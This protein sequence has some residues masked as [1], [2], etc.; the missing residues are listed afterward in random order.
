[1]GFQAVVTS[2]QCG[3]DAQPSPRTAASHM[4][5]P[6]PC[7]DQPVRSPPGSDLQMKLNVLMKT[8]AQ[9]GLLAITILCLVAAAFA[10]TQPRQ[11]DLNFTPAKTT[12]TF[13]LSASLHTVH[14]SFDL[15]RGAVHFD[16]ATNKLSG[17]IVADATSG[18][19]ENDGRD[20]KMHE[21]VLE[22]ARYPEIVFRPDRVE[23]QVAPTGVSTIQVHG[24]FS[25]HGAEHEMTIP[26]RV[27]IAPAHWIAT[28][29]FAIPYVKWGMKNPSTF[30]L[31]VD[32]SVDVEIKASGDIP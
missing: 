12:V 5:A 24:I 31:R 10:Q 29:Q 8:L 25:I 14:G 11:I 30:I 28:S 15:K 3:F 9:S 20:K 17:E 27:E 22:S 6:R 23:G 4:H 2:L 13:N 26:V 16:S 32:Q 1:M 19:T 18:R 7:I 21:Q